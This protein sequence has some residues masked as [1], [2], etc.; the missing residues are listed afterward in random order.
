MARS[1]LHHR[2]RCDRS[3]AVGFWTKADSITA[4]DDLTIRGVSVGG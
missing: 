2:D 3:G 4:F 1:C